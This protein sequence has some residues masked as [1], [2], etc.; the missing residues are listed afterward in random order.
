MSPPTRNEQWMLVGAG[1][2][3]VVGVF[4]DGYAHSNFVDEMDSFVTPWHGLI[5]FGYLACL[6]V[7]T[8]AVRARVIGGTG[9]VHAVP[10]GWNAPALGVGLFALGFLGDGVW[11]TVYGIEADLE[12]LLSPTHLLMLAGALAVMAGPLLAEWRSDATGRDAS[13]AELGPALASLTLIMATVSFFLNWT[14]PV[15][16]GRPLASFSEFAADQGEAEPVLN[17]LGQVS[18]V[19]SYL[20]FAVVLVAPILLLARRWEIPKGATFLVTMVPWVLMNAAFMSF[21]AWQ[22]L[23]P[24]VFGALAAELLL[25]RVQHRDG[26]WPW[27]L[28]GAALPVV[29]FGLDMV[30]MGV[31]WDLGWPPELIVGTVIGSGFVGYGVSVLTHPPAV[32]VS[33]AA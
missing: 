17:G 15:I 16:H 28:V 9:L 27:R 26:F 7:L 12:A 14:W 5:L 10:P 29:V 13:A 20:V 19:A 25:V 22:R 31:V 2:L 8:I 4:S 24:A 3:L 23:I 33:V 18:G 32:P 21:F 11:H 1:L 30:V 6:A